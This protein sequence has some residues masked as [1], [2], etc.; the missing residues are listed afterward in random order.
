MSVYLMCFPTKLEIVNMRVP[1]YTLKCSGTAMYV[2]QYVS[3]SI[4]A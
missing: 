3:L 1:C 4:F 2:V